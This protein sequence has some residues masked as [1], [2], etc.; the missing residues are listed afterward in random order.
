[1]AKLDWKYGDMVYLTGYHLSSRIMVIEGEAESRHTFIGFI[2]R[3]PLTPLGPS[4][5]DEGKVLLLERSF[6]T[7]IDE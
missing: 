4:A 1:M 7:L 5:S 6:H 2:I 3:E